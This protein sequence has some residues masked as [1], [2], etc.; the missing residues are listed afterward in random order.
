MKETFHKSCKETTSLI[1]EEMMDKRTQYFHNLL[2]KFNFDSSAMNTLDVNLLYLLKK[3]IQK[4]NRD[5][6]NPIF[7]IQHEPILVHHNKLKKYVVFYNIAKPKIY[8]LYEK[9]KKNQ[10]KRRG[11]IDTNLSHDEKLYCLKKSINI[12]KKELKEYDTYSKY[13][14]SLL[15]MLD[16]DLETIY[17]KIKKAQLNYLNKEKT[18]YKIFRY[19]LLAVFKLNLEKISNDSKNQRKKKYPDF[20]L[21]IHLEYYE[22]IDKRKSLA[23]IFHLYLEYYN[24]NF[25]LL[26]HFFLFFF[27]ESLTLT[28]NMLNN[29]FYFKESSISGTKVDR[30]EKIGGLPD[31]YDIFI[32]FSL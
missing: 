30:I 10:T 14:K 7:L 4:L 25:T 20:D 27:S 22:K 8:D 28:T 29:E 26:R 17:D 12:I 13:N 24:F 15:Y 1:F 18:E 19:I 21:L 23:Y 9:I 3:S 6:K 32:N 2:E 5:I 31:K 16:E 11:Y